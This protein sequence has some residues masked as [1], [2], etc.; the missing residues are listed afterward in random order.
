MDRDIIIAVSGII[1]KFF[2]EKRISKDAEKSMDDR[3]SIVLKDVN[4][5]AFCQDCPEK[6]EDY[7]LSSCVLSPI[8]VEGDPIGVVVISNKEKDR[9]I[10]DLELKLS[11]TAALFLAK[12]MEQ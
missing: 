1:R 5:N 10:G 9:E 3:R 2:L 8:I 12:Q 11:N 4:A 7:S 6:I